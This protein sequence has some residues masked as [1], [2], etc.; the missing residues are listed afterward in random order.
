MKKYKSETKEI[1]HDWDN[2]INEQD[3][4]KSVPTHLHHRIATGS[5]AE[6]QGKFD[7]MWAIGQRINAEH[8]DYK[9]PGGRVVADGIVKVGSA[10]GSAIQNDPQFM[11]DGSGKIEAVPGHEQMVKN[12][13]AV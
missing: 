2:G 3:Q 5:D 10:M 6:M 1:H 7:A 13:A 8:Y 12:F 11:Q 9:V 4:T